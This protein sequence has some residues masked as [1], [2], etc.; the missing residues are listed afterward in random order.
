MNVLA[1]QTFTSL[2]SS[3]QGIRSIY[4]VH[5]IIVVAIAAVPVTTA[6]VESWI[7]HEKVAMTSDIF[8]QI[9]KF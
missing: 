2:C 4:Y 6:M 1:R 9:S 5:N 7:G 8:E 3:L